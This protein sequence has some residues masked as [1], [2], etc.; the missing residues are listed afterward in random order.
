MVP[1][2]ARLCAQNH[3]TDVGIKQSWGNLEGWQRVVPTLCW[4][5][6]EAE[7]GT[8][9]PCQGLLPTSEQQ[10]LQPPLLQRVPTA[11]AMMVSH[12]LEEPNSQ[13][14][15]LASQRELFET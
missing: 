3:E 8:G 13:R 10:Q 7:V 2:P 11:S 6:L 9:V 12:V 15:G 4:S 14:W 1:E 5:L